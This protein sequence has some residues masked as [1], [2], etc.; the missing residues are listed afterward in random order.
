MRCIAQTH[1]NGLLVQSE[2]KI[3]GLEKIIKKLKKIT[4]VKNLGLDDD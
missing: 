4:K 3:E 2:N 1:L